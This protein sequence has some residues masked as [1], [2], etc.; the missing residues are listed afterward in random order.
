VPAVR[1]PQACREIV[2]E[3]SHPNDVGTTEWTRVVDQ[4]RSL[5]AASKGGVAWGEGTFTVNSLL[6]WLQQHTV[7]N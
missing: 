1:A 3:H 4:D 2:L 6:Q 5:D 7:T